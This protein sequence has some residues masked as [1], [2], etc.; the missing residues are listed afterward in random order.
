MEVTITFGLFRKLHAEAPDLN[1]RQ[2]F[3]K[4]IYR[5]H[6][7]EHMSEPLRILLRYACHRESYRMPY[8][9]FVKLLQDAPDLTPVELFAYLA[10]NEINFS[11]TL[12]EYGI[13]LGILEP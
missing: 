11:P 13:A 8:G 5:A 4:T 12:Q 9:A 6:M 2:M 3:T 1:L 7:H 10:M